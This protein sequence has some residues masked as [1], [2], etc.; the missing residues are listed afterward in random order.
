M[1]GLALTFWLIEVGGNVREFG[2]EVDLREVLHDCFHER[3]VFADPHG[4]RATGFFWEEEVFRQI[5]R[6][7]NFGLNHRLVSGVGNFGIDI[8]SIAEPCGG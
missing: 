7:G 5:F 4:G 3:G 1:D 6:F 2:F 8:D